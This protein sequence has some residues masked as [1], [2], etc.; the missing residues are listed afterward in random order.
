[1]KSFFAPTGRLIMSI[2]KDLIKDLPAALVELVKNSYDADADSVKI[3]FKKEDNFMKIIVEDNGHG[4]SENI[5][6]GWMVPS[7]S[8]KLEKKVSP[9]GRIYQGRKG[10]GRYAASLLGNKLKLITI[11]DGFKTTAVFNWDEF[12][13]DKKLSEIPIEINSVS[14]NEKNGTKLIIKNERSNLFEN[15]I[16]AD[17]VKNIENELA[18]LLSDESDFKISICYD[19][20]FDDISKNVC[21]EIH[22]V[23]FDNVCHYRL[24]GIVKKNF[25][26]ELTYYNSYTEEE[27]VFEGSF[28][29]DVN[30]DTVN[31]GDLHIDYKVYDKDPSGIELIMNFINSSN[32]IKLS[33]SEIKKS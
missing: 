18:K 1:M 28:K 11:H 21:K 7:T 10:I 6:L 22:P 3:T 2:G 19:N 16:N 30:N 13:T 12:E 25:D 5:V 14:T 24:S 9:R 33:K 26:Y 4:M 29:E 8:Y 32:N 23:K 17:S 27:K 15:E 31:C 20:F